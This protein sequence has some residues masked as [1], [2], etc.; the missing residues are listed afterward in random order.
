MTMKTNISAG[1]IARTLC[2]V[3]ALFN[4]MLTITGHAVL[5]IDDDT[6]NQVVSLVFTVGASVVAWW[7]NN[8]FTNAA[9]AADEYMAA[10]KEETEK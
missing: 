10:L 3:L 2:L 6:I 1:T 9:Q 8:S 5:P 4:Q 7:K